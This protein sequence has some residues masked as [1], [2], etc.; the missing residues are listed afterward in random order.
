MLLIYLGWFL[1]YLGGDEGCGTCERHGG[2][3]YA[4]DPIAVK[5]YTVV[6]YTSAERLQ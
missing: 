5:L 2:V 1:I 4:S 6:A 3:S